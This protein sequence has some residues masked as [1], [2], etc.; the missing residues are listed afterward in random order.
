V[1]VGRDDEDGRRAA[2]L[3]ASVGLADAVRG[4]GL[5]AG[6]W[7]SWN[8][9]SRSLETLRRVPVTEIAAW[10]EGE[11]PAQLLDVRELAEFEAGH[12][13]G[14]LHIPWREIDRI[15]AGIDQGRTVLVIC[16]SAQRAGTA[17]SLLQHYG[18]VDVVHVVEGG[19]PKWQALGGSLVVTEAVPEA[20]AIA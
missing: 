12:I 20:G 5:L 16:A 17:A 9:E 19:V 4:G 7:T 10:L 14:S 1:F 11:N 13:P 2:G 8:A 6:G 3:A 18:A 15:P